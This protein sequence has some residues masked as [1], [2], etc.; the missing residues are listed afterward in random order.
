MA[1]NHLLFLLLDMTSLKAWNEMLK[2]NECLSLLK[3]MIVE[4]FEIKNSV[5]DLEQ[6]IYF[7][8]VKFY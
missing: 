5:L 7:S 4:N 6:D 2:A 1:T 3:E 8:I